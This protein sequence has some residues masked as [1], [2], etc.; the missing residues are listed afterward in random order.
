M[1]IIDSLKETGA[2]IGINTVLNY[3]EKDPEKNLPKIVSWLKRFDTKGDYKG[4]YEKLDEIATNPEN[5]WFK[6]IQRL[7]AEVDTNVFKTIFRNFLLYSAIK[8]NDVGKKISEKEDCNIPWAI[9]LDP[10]SACNLR[11]T[12]CWAA[13]YGYQFNLTYDEIDSIVTQGKELGTYMYI[14]TGGEPLMRKKDIIKLCEKHNDCVFLCFTNGTLIDEEFAQDMLRVRN[15]VPSIS[16]EGFEVETD[17]RRGE[18]TYQAIVHA[19][20]ILKRNKLPFGISCCYTKFNTQTIG[21]EAYIDDVINKGALFAW[22]FTYM[23]VGMDTTTDLM[24]TPEQREYMYYQLRR[25]RSTKPLFTMDFWNDGEFVGGCIA[26]GRRYLHIN[27]NGDVE[28]CVF[29]HYSDSNIREKT[30]LEAYKSPMFMAYRRNQ[31]F[32]DNML[33]PCPILDNPGRLEEMVKSVGAKSTDFKNPE[34]PQNLT[35]KCS[36]V[37]GQWKPVADNLW[38]FEKGK[39][40]GYEACSQSCRTCGG[41]VQADK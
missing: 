30:L 15:F 12:G 37:A 13:E 38:D 3:L 23:P 33:R 20:D 31:P 5:N 22:F 19:M 14:Y 34:D 1:G 9:L 29:A 11:C 27:A 17:S 21:S 25:F 26:G 32:S 16:I 6:F 35:R 2:S 4:V 36:D 18:G 39:S 28:P 8:G 41:C 24:V 10:T 7:Y 40:K